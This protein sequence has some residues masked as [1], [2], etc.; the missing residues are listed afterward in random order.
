MDG[1]SLTHL[2]HATLRASQAFELVIIDRLPPAEQAALEELRR[3]PSFYGVLR[4]RSDNGLTVKAVDRDTAL[5]WLTLQQA[6]PAPSFVWLEDAAAAAD[7]LRQLIL[8]GVLEIEHD[9]TFVSGAGAVAAL[10]AGEPSSPAQGRLAALSAAALRYAEQLDLADH[11]RLA[12]RLYQY[13]RLPRSAAWAD[14]LP[15]VSSV[16]AF[17]GVSED[18]VIGRRLSSAWRANETAANGWIAW[19]NTRTM[20]ASRAPDQPTYKLYVSPMPS[21]FPAAFE[22]VVNLGRVAPQQFKIGSDAS[23]ILR[24][25]KMVLYFATLEQLQSAGAELEHR[26]AGLAPHGVPFSAEIG[27]DGL[28]SWGMDPPATAR[29]V[30]WQEPESWRLWVAR[31]LAAALIA[32]QASGHA[33]GGAARFALERLRLEGVD[34][35][36]WTP[37]AAL[38]RHAP[39]NAQ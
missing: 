5:M 16:L 30:S 33:K 19:A 23:G 18:T 37:S 1:T 13:G 29:V 32:A 24:P 4:P 3:D 8:D 7:G 39:Q 17:A 10:G 15:D 35:D 25:D 22:E 12:A 31:R 6:G 28:L 38:W 26:L 11:N 20:A 14:R 2:A 9:G 36:R 21:D 27:G 34:V